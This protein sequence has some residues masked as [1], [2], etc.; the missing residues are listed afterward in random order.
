MLT[1]GNPAEVQNLRAENMLT[2]RN[3]S[4]FRTTSVVFPRDT[5]TSGI[6]KL[7]DAVEVSGGSA[8]STL[9]ATWWFKPKHQKIA[10]YYPLVW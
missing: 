3:F 2:Y 5:Y 7:A 6:L 10:L 8:L 4:S 1:F 9:S